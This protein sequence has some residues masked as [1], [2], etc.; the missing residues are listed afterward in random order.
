MSQ[1]AFTPLGVAPVTTVSNSDGTLVVS[2]NTGAV[3]AS[4]AN[5]LVLG[6]GG[7]TPVAGTYNEKLTG[8]VN[9]YYQVSLQNTNSGS[10]ASTDFVV[11]ADNG[12]DS[13]HYADFGINGSTGASTPFTAAN[14]AYLYSIDSE[15]DIG[16]LGASGV[17]KIYTTGGTSPVLAATF[18]ATQKLVLVNPLGAAS[19]GTGIANNAAST[20]TISGSFGTTFTVSATT[21]VTLPNSGTLYGT[22]SGSISSAQ[23]AASMSDETGSGVLVFGTDPSLT[24]ATPTTTSFGYLGAPQNSQSAAYTLLITDAGKHIY[25]PDADTTA[26][27]FTIPANASVAFPIGTVICIQNGNGAGVITLAITSDTLR[28][29]AST[30]S[31]SIAANGTATLLKVTST[32]WRLTG[33]GIT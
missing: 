30:G 6:A 10:T 11:T 28:W 17:V 22:A 20:I 9:N 21:S 23:L 4:V 19:G 25:H 29:Q 1:S 12:T 26:R 2:P 8:S 31:R 16:A 18:D 5:P 14:A 33:D 13:T 32:V 7:Y 24:V 27:I 15:L 3:V